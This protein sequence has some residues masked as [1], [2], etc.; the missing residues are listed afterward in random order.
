MRD[1]LEAIALV[2]RHQPANFEA[3]NADEVNR[4]FT[5]KQVEI[6]GEA[7]FKTTTE[8]KAAHP[9]VPWNA[10]EKTRHV[11]VHDYF[12]IEWQK[13]WDVVV[14]HLDPLRAQVERIV[15]ELGDAESDSSDTPHHG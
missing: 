11:F 14:N 6:M 12:E 3:F 7:V 4:Y 13:L 9:E 1:I 8:L 5:L 15:A 2:R 10:I